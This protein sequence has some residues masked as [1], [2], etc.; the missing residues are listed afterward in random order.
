MGWDGA[1]GMLAYMPQACIF[2]NGYR[3]GFHVMYVLIS[4]TRGIW[5]S[6]IIFF[7]I[8]LKPSVG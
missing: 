7:Q 8:S 3:T 6:K 5:F 4:F 1:S 2:V